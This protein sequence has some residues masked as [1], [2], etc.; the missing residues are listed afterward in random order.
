[1]AIDP[2][3]T[4]TVVVDADEDDEIVLDVTA[5]VEMFTTDGVFEVAVV[6]TSRTP[7]V[8]GIALLTTE[9]ADGAAAPFLKVIYTTPPGGRYSE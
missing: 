2:A 7:S 6:R 5:L 8:S 9:S 3:G 1:M 4:P